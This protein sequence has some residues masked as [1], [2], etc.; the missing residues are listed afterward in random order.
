MKLQER[1]DEMRTGLEKVCDC[2]GCGE[3]EGCTNVFCAIRQARYTLDS[4]ENQ[5]VE[6]HLAAIA[7]KQACFR[8]G[9]MDMRESAAAALRNTA[10]KTFG[11]TRHALLIAAD[12]VKELGVSS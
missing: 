9:Q 4:L 1:I 3:V 5:A 10:D 11:N 7:E 8:L 6:L 12:V 2:V